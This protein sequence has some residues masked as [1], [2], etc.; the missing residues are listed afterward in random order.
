MIDFVLDVCID[1][2]SG[3]RHADLFL[4]ELVIAARSGHPV[5]APDVKE[6]SLEILVEVFHVFVGVTTLGV[7]SSVDWALGVVGKV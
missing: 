1:D 7:K 4:S 6:L 2:A 3:I 5:I